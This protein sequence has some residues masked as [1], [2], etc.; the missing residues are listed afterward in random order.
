[1][2]EPENTRQPCLH[3]CMWPRKYAPH[4]NKTNDLSSSTT[5]TSSAFVRIYCSSV[6]WFHIEILRTCS[7]LSIYYPWL[8]NAIH[9]NNRKWAC[10]VSALDRRIPENGTQTSR[11]S[12]DRS[13]LPVYWHIFALALSVPYASSAGVESLCILLIFFLFAFLVILYLK[14]PCSCLPARSLLHLD[15]AA[16]VA[17]QIPASN[18]AFKLKRF[19]FTVFEWRQQWLKVLKMCWGSVGICG[20]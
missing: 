15:F 14:F 19:I 12:A 6:F 7:H 4:N 18:V 17:K 10:C 11:A 5:G 20:W 8:W 9:L 13:T 2:K 1:M 3:Q 16:M